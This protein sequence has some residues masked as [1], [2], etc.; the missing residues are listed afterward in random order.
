MTA[1]SDWDGPPEIKELRQTVSDI[2]E[3]LFHETQVARF[4]ISH[5]E[6]DQAPEALRQDRPERSIGAVYHCE[7]PEAERAAHYFTA[8][9]ADQFDAVFTSTRPAESSRSNLAAEKSAWK[10][11]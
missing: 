10:R 1:A 6:R 3:A 5:G 8:R 4:M 7:T 9:L 11:R 2:Y